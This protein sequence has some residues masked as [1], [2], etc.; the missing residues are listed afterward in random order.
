M[1]YTALILAAAAALTGCTWETY[2]NES[3]HTSLRPKYEKGTRIYYEDGTYSRDMRYNQYRPERRTLKPLHGD[4]ENVRGTVWN[5]PQGAGQAAP[6][7]QTEEESAR[8]GRL[9]PPFPF[10]TTSN[11]T[12]IPFVPYLP[13][14]TRRKPCVPSP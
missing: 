5:K 4:Q 10:Q 8:R 6:E 7:T 11:I 3:G 13:S 14:F 1:R 9:K 12:A 2:Q